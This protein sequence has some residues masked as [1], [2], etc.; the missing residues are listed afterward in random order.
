MQKCTCSETTRSMD[1]LCPSCKAEYDQ[2]T[3]LVAWDNL[4]LATLPPAAAEAYIATEFSGVER[5]V[6]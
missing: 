2:L 6:N 4:M 1:E 3:A 5:R